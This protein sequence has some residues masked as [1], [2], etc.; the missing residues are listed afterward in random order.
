[1]VR[2]ISHFGY[3]S[4]CGPVAKVCSTRAD[5]TTSPF[6]KA[7][8]CSANWCLRL[9]PVC[10]MYTLGHPSHGV[11]QGHLQLFLVQFL[12]VSCYIVYFVQQTAICYIWGPNGLH[13]LSIVKIAAVV[14]VCLVWAVICQF[15][16]YDNR[17]ESACAWWQNLLSHS[18]WKT[19]YYIDMHQ[20]L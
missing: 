18:S 20:Y 12:L 6:L 1:M 5:A 11:K 13:V 15:P 10:S 7:R 2:V 17:N 3:R 4:P 9:Q 16:T 19:T 14:G 8:W